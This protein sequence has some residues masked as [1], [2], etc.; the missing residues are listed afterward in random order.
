MDDIACE[1]RGSKEETK[2]IKRLEIRMKQMK[3]DLYPPTL[4]G[5]KY[6]PKMQTAFITYIAT[7]VLVL[8]AGL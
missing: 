2:E 7:G 6:H 5:F 4:F 3:N 1:S 8:I